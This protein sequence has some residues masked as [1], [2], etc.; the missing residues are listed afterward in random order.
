MKYRKKKII[1]TLEKYKPKTIL[2]IGC[3]MNPIFQDYDEKGL[4]YTIVEPSEYFYDHAVKLSSNSQRI[5]CINDFF[6]S[7][8]ASS[9]KLGNTF[10]FI[11]CSSLLHEIENSEEMLNDIARCCNENTVVHINVPNAYSMHRILAKESAMI[12]DIHQ[13][14]QRN[15]QFQQNK[16]F[17]LQ[18]LKETVIQNGLT[19][20]DEGSYFI[21][22]FSHSQMYDLLKTGIIDER[23]LDGF[24]RMIQWMPEYG[25]EIFVNCKK[26]V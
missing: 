16:V 4:R 23:V 21:K 10:D 6:G 20:I 12:S 5:I 17:D 9:E 2:E 14:S 24:Y 7:N 19:I 3:G 13:F 11:I 26:C 1:E 15:Q 8:E 22:P 25:S 18:A